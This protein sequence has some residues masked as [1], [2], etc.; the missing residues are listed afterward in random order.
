ME[1]IVERGP[2]VERFQVIDTPNRNQWEQFVFDHP[3]GSIFH[4]PAMY[5]VYQGAK[6]YDPSVLA[7]IDDR[8]N[9]LALLCAVRV[10]TLPD[11]LGRLASRSILYAEPLCCEGPAG[12]EAL[13]AL[14]AEHDARMRNR[15]L[16][17]EVRP[18][19]PAGV[20]KQ[21]LDRCGYSHEGYLNFLIDL[22]KPRD[23]LWRAMG[24]ECR[25]RVKKNAEKGLEIKD[26]TNPEGV[27]ILYGILK[28]TFERVRVPL[29]DKSL[30]SQGL[31]VLGP[32]GRIKLSVTY[33]Q[34]EP[35]GASALLLYKKYI[36]T[37]FGA[38]KRMDAIQP[39]EFITWYEIEWGHDA[40]YSIYDFGGAGWPDKPYPV[41]DFKRKFGGDLVNYGRYRR[42]YSP[43]KLALAEKGYEFGRNVLNPKYWRQTA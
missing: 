42:V 21:A 24:K 3:K 43:V 23:A 18:L 19:R 30:F 35:V 38:A 8:G 22:T 4:T 29:A 14:I 2:S 33:F 16:F 26:M 25:R 40:G 28:P 12:A 39:T 1:R 10:L 37:W 13:G 34:G 5:D 11:P 31:N 6:H 36:F 27:A 20:E 32:L 17:T 7:A 15:V 41:R 9:I